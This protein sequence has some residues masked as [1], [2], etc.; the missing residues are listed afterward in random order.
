MIQI[1]IEMPKGCIDCPCS[2]FSL[3]GVSCN[4]IAGE[5]LFKREFVTDKRPE[6]C[7]LKEVKNQYIEYWEN[8]LLKYKEKP[9]DSN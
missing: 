4:T 9:N 7:P 6:C 1:D 5:S 3:S 2:A 8:E